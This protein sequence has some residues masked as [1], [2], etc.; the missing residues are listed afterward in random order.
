[1]ADVNADGFLDIYVC[2]AG[3]IKD[4]DREN[5]L[6]INNG[7]L[8]FTEKGAEYNLNAKGYATHAAFLITTWTAISDAYILNNSFI[9]V[10][11]LNYEN[12]R[13]LYAE[14]WPVKDFLKNG[15]GAKI[16]SQR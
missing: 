6:F 4:D 1:M 8:T 11:T 9:P 2:N 10:N 13:E 16:T 14:D 3:Y 7:D 15:G 5:E 12:K